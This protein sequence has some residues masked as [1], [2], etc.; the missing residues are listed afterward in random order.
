[1]KEYF[2]V[3]GDILEMPDTE[4]NIRICKTTNDEDFYLLV[5]KNG[6]PFWL[7]ISIFSLRDYYGYPAHDV[8][9]ELRWCG[10][11][12]TY[13]D[14]VLAVLGRTIECGEWKEIDVPYLVTDA[15][16]EEYYYPGNVERVKIAPLKFI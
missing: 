8:C 12:L 6:K 4:Q 9:R 3:P 16:M 1:M 5:L 14:D 15:H 11:C 2:L 13:A 10:H 7:D